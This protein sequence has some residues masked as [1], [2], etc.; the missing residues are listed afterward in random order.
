M[1]KLNLQF[2]ISKPFGLLKS[3]QLILLALVSILFINTDDYRFFFKDIGPI[4]AACLLVLNAL[5]YV[6]HLFSIDQEK[7]D[8]NKPLI[9]FAFL[10]FFTALIGVAVFALLAVL[11]LC[12]RNGYWSGQP[13]AYSIIYAVLAFL[14]AYFFYLVYRKAIDMNQGVLHTLVLQEE[15]I[16][17]NLPKEFLNDFQVEKNSFHPSV[18]V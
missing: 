15:D 10:E 6:F 3:A 7:N 14:F 16:H 1:V 2:P 17:T 4:A 18:L 11:N 8:Q 13:A 9:P 5:S 12:V